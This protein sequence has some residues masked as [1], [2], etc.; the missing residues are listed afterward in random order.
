MLGNLSAAYFYGYA[1]M[2]VPVGMMLDRFGPRRLMT[3]AALLCAAGAAMF[4]RPV[5]RESVAQ[6]TPH[7]A[8]RAPE[9]SCA[10]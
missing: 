8:P 9:R 3:I 10:R 1:G 5:R 6:R 4:D 2:Q 7:P